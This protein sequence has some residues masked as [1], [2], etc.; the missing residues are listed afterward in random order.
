MNFRA[1]LIITQ[2][3]LIVLPLLV[4]GWLLRDSM[5]Q[6]L[7]RQYERRVETMLDGIST[8]LEIR[9][10]NL[11]DRLAALRAV[12]ETDQALELALAGLRDRASYPADFIETGRRLG[13]LDLLV[14]A[15]RNGDVRA[16]SAT[17]FPSGRPTRLLARALIRR[18]GAPGLT[19]PDRLDDLLSPDAADL[20]ARS[21]SSAPLALVAVDSLTLG[22]RGCY[23]LGGLIVDRAF[24]ADLSGTDD[25]T[26]SLVYDGG[27]IPG[28]IGDLALEGW[29]LSAGAGSLS[30]PQNVVPGDRYL[31]TGI[32]FPAAASGDASDAIN[33]P[34]LINASLVLT[35]PRSDWYALL[36]D[37]DT[38]LLAVLLMVAIGAVAASLLA[39]SRITRPLSDLARDTAS[40]DVENLDTAFPVDRPDE[41]G[42]LARYMD[43]MQTRLRSGLETLRESERRAAL[44]DL[45]RQV[46]HDIRNGFLPLRN[47]IRHLQTVAES[48]PQRLEEVFSDRLPTMDASLKYLEDLA[49]D[50]RRLSPRSARESVDLAAAIRG[51]ISGFPETVRFREPPAP[52]HV[53]AEPTAL[54]RIIQNLVRNALQSLES[55]GG[56]VD[57]EIEPGPDADRDVTVLIRDDGCGMSPE[58]LEKST[59]Q[60]FTTRPD[61]TG[62]GLSIVRRL[63]ADGNHGFEM[64]SEPGR[65]TVARL[66]FE[67][68]G[69]VDP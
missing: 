37:L 30:D 12:A 43:A 6:R 32:P 27:A 41:V 60:F 51:A 8:R 3:L 5:S 59:R 66:V 16:A 23:L 36:R 46:T 18:G 44:G 15:E 35:H 52:L 39:A 49:G 54:R 17:A 4:L 33:R 14:L 53:D 42:A 47:V 48:D 61:G 58:I 25:V 40:V 64:T 38:W 20:L 65:G 10:Q 28:D 9:Q 62:L 69:K 7:G 45:A 56:R 50:Y 29:L 55:E 13:G 1:R 26:A 34:P 21:P 57:I 11:V 19:I 22:G 2:I 24:I 63:A 67:K 68:T 31:A